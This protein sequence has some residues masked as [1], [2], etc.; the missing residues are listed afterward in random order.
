LSVKP[1]R[2]A[3]SQ[4]PCAIAGA[5]N[6]YRMPEVTPAT[7]CSSVHW[8]GKTGSPAHGQTQRAPSSRWKRRNLP[9]WISR[10]GCGSDHS[11]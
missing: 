6:R 3:P 2:N 11:G 1:T 7:W 10:A 9:K 4:S 5:A 8:C